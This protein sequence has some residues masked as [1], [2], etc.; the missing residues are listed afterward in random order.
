MNAVRR[1][2]AARNIT[3]DFTKGTLVLFMVLYHWLNYFVASDGS[4]YNYLRFITPSFIF[5]A[6]FL[7]A[8]VYPAKYESGSARAFRRLLTRGL[9]LL[10]LFTALN[11]AANLL[12]ARSYKGSMP[13][14]EGF[15]RNAAA[16]YVSGTA[17]A[18]FIVLVP[19]S[20]LVL[21]SAPLLLLQRRFRYAAHVV[22][23]ACFLGVAI[24]DAYSISSPNL[25]LLA[26]GL[27]GMVCGSYPLTGI[28]RW[29]AQSSAVLWCNLAYVIVI[30]VWG[31]GYVLQTIGVCLSLALI[32]LVGMKSDKWIRFREWLVRL[33]KYSLFGYIAQI[34]LLQLLQRG[35]PHLNLDVWLLLAVSF[36]AAFVLTSATVEIVHSM[37]ARSHALDAVYRFT[38]S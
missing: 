12:F 18:P 31:V 26:I 30:S 38:F 11:L 36:V 22:C 17:K 10:A 23:A 29:I 2:A 6:G 4:I 32:Y 37:R 9:K 7:I 27:L 13:G 35:L 28:E 25:T 20:Y 15:V 14:I 8:N 21:L 16:I 19:I 5:I 24:F 3:L 34:F 1:D 33:G